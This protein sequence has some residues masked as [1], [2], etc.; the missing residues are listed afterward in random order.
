MKNLKILTI[1]GLSAIAGLAAACSSGTNTTTTSNTT[2]ANAPARNTAGVTNSNNTTTAEKPSEETP[3]AVKAAFPDANS[4]T[5]QHKDIPPAQI[6]EIE[7]EAGAKLPDTDHHSYL[8]FSTTGG[9]RKQIGAATVVEAK[10]KEIVVVY[11]NKEG[12]PYIKELRADGVPAPFL[13]QFVGKGHDDK[14]QIGAD[15][16]ANGVDDA[17]AKAIAEAIRVDILTMQTLYGAPEKH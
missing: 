16:K 5:K 6:A 1:I 15:L 2:T 3:A 13:A 12:K 10:G 17:T 14:F 8:A 7:K 11:E 9:G 4:F